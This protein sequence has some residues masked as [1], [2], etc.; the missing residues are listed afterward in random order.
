MHKRRDIQ[1]R[2]NIQQEKTSQKGMRHNKRKANG[3][4]ERKQG[5]SIKYNDTARKDVQSNTMTF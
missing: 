5:H 1:K 2:R 3:F 4:I